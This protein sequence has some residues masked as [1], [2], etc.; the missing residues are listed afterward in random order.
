MELSPSGGAANSAATQEFPSILWN[1]KVHYRVH[2]S[3]PL[4]PILS[5]INPIHTIPSY[6]YK[7]ILI[8]S[9]HLRLGLPCGLLPS[10]FPT[11]ILYA[12]LWREAANILNKQSRTADKGWTSS[13]VVGR[14]AN[15]SSP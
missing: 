9:T 2:K 10:G 6:L 7:I 15:N 5:H 11:N 1:P 3:P 13:S 14:E 8:L 4:L 12:F